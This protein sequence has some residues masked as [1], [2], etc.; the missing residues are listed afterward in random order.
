[1]IDIEVPKLNNND[2]AYVLVEWL[3]EDGQELKEGDPLVVIETSKAAEELSCAHGGILHRLVA[4]PADCG[5][6]DVIAHLFASEADRQEFLAGRP[7]DP[8]PAVV[9][10]SAEA[11]PTLTEPARLLAQRHGIEP[12]ALSRLGLRVV[13]E[14]DVRRLLSEASQ[15]RKTRIHTPNRAQRAVAAAVSQSHREIPAAFTA[16]VVTVDSAL[17]TAR[18][19]SERTGALIGLPEL[20]VAV[21]GRLHGR[22][23]LC[24]GTPTDEG[25]LLL[26]EEAHVGVTV[27]VG[28]G[29]FAPVVKNAGERTLD[30]IAG[31]LMDYRIK[32][33]REA[34]QTDDLNGANILLSLNN[35]DDVLL[36]QPIVFPGQTCAVAL[37]GTRREA[38]FADDGAVI[39]RSVAVVGL[40]YDHRFVNGSTAVEFLKAIKEGLESPPTGLGDPSAGG[41]TRGGEAGAD[42]GDR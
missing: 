19:L 33:M 42:A 25:T 7:A 13:R 32:T 20:L 34:F 40:A 23:P 4:A 22:F 37:A 9:D 31:L 27:D 14:A 3:A 15:D 29:L 41:G 17:A 1:M 38:V 26:P 30:E 18:E 8:T 28:R 24:Y 12:A 2:T 10:D 35:N 21:L 5:Q 6:G 16:V 39:P 36:A 11:L